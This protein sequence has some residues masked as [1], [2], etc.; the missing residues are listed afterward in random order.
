LYLLCNII[1]IILS[2]DCPYLLIPLPQDYY[3]STR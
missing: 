3:L 1:S 2:Q